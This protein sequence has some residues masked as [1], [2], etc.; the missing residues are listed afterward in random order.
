M[1]VKDLK[2]RERTQGL[3]LLGRLLEAGSARVRGRRSRVDAV[4]ML[5]RV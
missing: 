3:K 1:T 5:G 2:D 4:F